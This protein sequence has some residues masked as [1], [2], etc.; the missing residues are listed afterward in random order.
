MNKIVKSFTKKKQLMAN[1]LE[2]NEDVTTKF[3]CGFWYCL[4]KIF[5]YLLIKS[6]FKLIHAL[7]IKFLFFIYDFKNVLKNHLNPKV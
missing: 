3:F 2:E 7:L 5:F 4:N 6:F 1:L